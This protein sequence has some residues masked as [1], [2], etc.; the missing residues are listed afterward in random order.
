[1]RHAL[2]KTL[3]ASSVLLAL[4]SQAAFATNGLA[5]TGVG[6]E[7]RAMGG[8]AVANASNTMSMGTN[9]AAASFIDDGYDVGVEMFVPNRSVKTNAAFGPYSGIKFDGNDESTFFIPEAGYKKQINDK[10]SV[11]VVAYGNGGMN[12]S[13]TTDPFGGAL[14]GTSGLG[15][16]G[17]DYKQLFVSP[18]ISYKLNDNHAIGLSANLVHHQFKARVDGIGLTTDG[19]YPTESNSGVGAT[20]G[21]QGKL[22]PNLSAGVSYRTKTNM[23][24][25]K[26]YAGLGK[27]DVPAAATAGIA[28]QAAPNTLITADVQQIKY[29]GVEAIGDNFGWDDQTVYKLGVKHQATDNVALMAGYN[30]GKSPLG[31]EDTTFGVLAPAIVENHVSLGT[32]VKVGPKSKIIASYVH[33]FDKELKGDPAKGGIYDLKMSQDAVGIA[34]SQ[35]F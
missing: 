9:P 28:Y 16:T 7:Q 6:M 2:N 21:W 5:P 17:V 15:K 10:V 20:I 32:E 31:A 23:G 26:K 29:S 22:S 34:F 27:M 3:L 35:E 14:T 13:Y 33:A 1:M 18:T 25:F 19:S 24:D 8:A 11:G 12:T 30:H 4:G